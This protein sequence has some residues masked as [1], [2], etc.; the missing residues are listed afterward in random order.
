MVIYMQSYASSGFAPTKPLSR[1]DLIFQQE[2]RIRN[3]YLR[4]QNEKSKSMSRAHQSAGAKT[5]SKANEMLGFSNPRAKFL[6]IAIGVCLTLFAGQTLV[7]YVHHKIAVDCSSKVVAGPT[8][9][10]TRKY[11]SKIVTS[12][13]SGNCTSEAQLSTLIN[14]Y[15]MKQAAAEQASVT[16]SAK[17]LSA[18]S[19]ATSP[20]VP[21]A[22]VATLSQMSGRDL[23][24]M[25]YE[26][27]RAG[28]PQESVALFNEAVR[29]D[30]SN[31]NSRRYLAYALVSAGRASEA[32]EQY[33]ALQKLNA[34]LPADRLAM[35]H[36]LNAV[37][38][39][40]VQSG[41]ADDEALVSHYRAALISNPKDFD[42]KYRLAVL[43][44]KLG[45]NEEAIHECL[46]GM[47]EA[48]SAT[49]KQQQFYLLYASLA[50]TN[51]NRT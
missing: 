25:G 28:F 24:Q 22:V 18:E 16:K 2:R 42:A 17:S 46:T 38:T 13:T 49:D 50:T 39:N 6:A 5:Q 35:Q 44:S 51:P 9:D 7:S 47:S 4:G 8:S 26:K 37:Q 15:R 23:L 40:G 45:R 30:S 48:P 33:N 3:D 29:R 19:T 32:L 27:L 1:G 21:T 11:V 14:T 43:C 34:L 10:A 36:A 31:A 20:S 12:E 41:S